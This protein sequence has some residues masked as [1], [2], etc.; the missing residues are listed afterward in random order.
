[1]LNS[2][3]TGLDCTVPLIFEERGRRERREER[4]ERERCGCAEERRLWLYVL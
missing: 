4:G 2:V 1:M 3:Y